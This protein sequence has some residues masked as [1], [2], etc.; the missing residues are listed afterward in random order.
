MALAAYSFPYT[1]ITRYPMLYAH[2]IDVINL[3]SPVISWY[4]NHNAI[5]W[6]A[7]DKPT[8][9]AFAY[10]AFPFHHSTVGYRSG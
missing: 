3:D 4:M 5:L 2:S 1:S 10:S 9:L 7:D 8:E 6:A